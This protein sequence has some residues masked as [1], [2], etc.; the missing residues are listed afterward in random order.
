MAEQFYTILTSIGKA[1]IAN[2]SALGA[3]VDFT[4]LALGDGGGSYYNPTEDQ[5]KLRNEVYRAQI[6]HVTV[7]EENPNWITISIV[8][9]AVIGGFTIREGGVFDTEG[10]MLA[11][12]KYP[13]TYKP[14]LEEGSSK[15]ITVNMVIEVSNASVVNLK[16]DPTVIFA[17]KKDIESRM[18]KGP[19]TWGHLSSDV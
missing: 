3:K 13:E 18:P 10:N 8:I 19:I 15:D 9:P 11:V 7:D 16:I 14:V 1:K 4:Y 5:T 6:N 12:G 2:A 17:T